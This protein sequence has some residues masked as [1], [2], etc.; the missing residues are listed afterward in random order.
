[1][2]HGESDLDAMREQMVRRQIEARGIRD[3][4]VLKAMR[5]IRRHEFV[6]A[7]KVAHAYE[8]G[9]LPIGE[10][11]TISQPYIV[12]WMT[13]LLEIQPGDDV[14]EVGCGCGYQTAVLAQLAAHVYA[15]E[16]VDTLTRTAR[17]NLR[18]AGVENATVRTGD[19]LRG[20]PERAPF[21]R[22]LAA[23]APADVPEEL[24][25]EL[26]VGGRMVLPVGARGD[27]HMLRL[28]RDAS[29]VTREDLGLVAFVP[30]IGD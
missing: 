29:G 8:D 5:T 25:R 30:M 1:M 7:G 15:I 20:W 14:L 21:F 18:R 12:A 13:E 22:I 10:G 28:T 19:G 24:M 17:L 23:A 27:Q 16:R 11:Q 9:P 4:R 3:P 6:P 2:S 26:A